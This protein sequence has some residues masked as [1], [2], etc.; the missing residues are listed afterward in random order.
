MKQYHLKKFYVDLGEI[1]IK[2]FEM[3]RKLFI[4]ENN[5]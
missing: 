3:M 1:S 5:A 4:L 2:A